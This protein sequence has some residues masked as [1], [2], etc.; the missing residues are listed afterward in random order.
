[1]SRALSAAGYESLVREIKSR[2]RSAQTKAAVSVNREL[3]SL[4]WDIGRAIVERQREEGWGKGVVERLAADLQSEFSGVSGFSSLNIWR[5][6]AFYLAWTE[7]LSRAVTEF[8]AKEVSRLVTEIPW[9]H[10]IDLIQKVKDPLR[11][12]WY[13]QQTVANGWSRAVMV[14]QIESNLFKR[15]GGAVTNF[16]RTLPPTKSDLARQLLK[17][18]YNFDF[19]TLREDAQEKEL[20]AG[21]MARVRDFLVELGSG[22]AFVGQ[23]VPLQVDCEDFY[24]DLLFYHL[25]LRCYV[26]IDLKVGAFKPEYAG[27][28]NFYLSAVDDSL[29]H[30]DDGAS[31]G[32][33]LCK[34]RSKVIAE[35]ALRDLAKPV[36][37]ARYKLGAALPGKYR[38]LLPTK[39]ELEEGLGGELVR[40]LN[41][42]ENRK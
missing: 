21:L 38:G 2:I 24:I 36:G 26:V 15:Q 37:V 28:M 23:Q 19:L 7:E 20:E 31:V 41:N 17:D 35:Y 18:P 3:I 14:H 1:M 5:M 32:L 22:F 9:G 29:R 16:G 40:K 12:L 10:N 30:P 11:R 8:D 27:K 25:R 34:A 42:G 39:R 13:A 6:R 33:I 4:Y